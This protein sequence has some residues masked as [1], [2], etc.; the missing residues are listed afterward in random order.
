MKILYWAKGNY[1]FLLKLTITIGLST[2]LLYSCNPAVLASTMSNI[3]IYVAGIAFTTFLILVLI[4]ALNLWM[5]LNSISC[6]PFKLFMQSYSYGY[7]LNLF[8]PGQLADISMAYFLKEHGVYYSRSTLAYFVDKLISMFFI[9][10]LVYIGA[11]YIIYF[12]IKPIFITIIP[13]VAIIIVIVLAIVLVCS[14]CE[15]GGIGRVKRLIT[16][17]YKEFLDWDNKVRSIIVNI[18][19]TIVKWFVVSITYYL[20]FYAFGIKVPWPEIGIIPVMSSL[21]GYIPISAGGIGTVELC[22]VYLFSLISIDKVYVIDVYIFLRLI[23]YV[24]AGIILAFCNWQ[25]RRART[26][27]RG[28]AKV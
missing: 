1:K 25:F 15:A 9:F 16:N 5:M 10:I 8:A 24:Q 14:P 11:K 6:I 18:L 2:Y 27:Q 7:A 12:G 26:L 3:N 20:T 13:F 23:T 28:C 22:S 4:G 19:L 21:I 17:M